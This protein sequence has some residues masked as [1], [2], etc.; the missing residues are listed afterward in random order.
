MKK[1]KTE[2]KI[3]STNIVIRVTPEQKNNL[4]SR[5]KKAGV[6]MAALAWSKIFKGEKV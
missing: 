6:K 4:K 3:K 5:A 1:I 2:N